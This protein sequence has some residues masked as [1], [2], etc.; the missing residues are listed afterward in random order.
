MSTET[1][2]TKLEPRGSEGQTFLV[3]DTL[4]LRG[5]ELGDA[6]RASAWRSSPFPVAAAQAEEQ[7]KELEGRTG[8]SCMIRLVA[9]RRADDAQ[10]GSVSVKLDDWQ[11]G[12]LTLHVDPVFAPQA[13]TLKAEMLRLLAPWL[14]AEVDRLILWTWI[15]MAPGDE[16][17]RTA[18]DELGF[19]ETGRLR[20]AIWRDG[21]RYDYCIYETISPVLRKGIG[22]PADYA[23]PLPERSPATAPRLR[24]VWLENPPRNAVVVGERVYLRPEEVEDAELIA[25]WSRRETDTFHE[26][27]IPYPHSGW[28]T[29]SRTPGRPMCRTTSHS[30]SRSAKMTS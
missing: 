18:A 30:A 10:V 8:N 26:H 5:L 3:G 11:A 24:P 7:L 21:A 9:C 14:Q 2:P 4:Y 29:G 12:D 16:P 6:K 25:R 19:A 17:L 28:R 20:E 27:R 15:S 22:E 23:L 13:G 1:T